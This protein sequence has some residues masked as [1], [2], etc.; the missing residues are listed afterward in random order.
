MH[1]RESYLIPDPFHWRCGVVENAV[2][3]YRQRQRYF[4]AYLLAAGV[5]SSLL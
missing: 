5:P 2:D 1:G 3:G 4:S